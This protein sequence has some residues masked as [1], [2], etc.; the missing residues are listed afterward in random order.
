MLEFLPKEIFSAK[1]R[2][3]RKRICSASKKFQ[4]LKLDELEKK[5]DFD[6]RN[7]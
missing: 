6:G 2:I 5:R 4:D 3:W 7:V 1:Q